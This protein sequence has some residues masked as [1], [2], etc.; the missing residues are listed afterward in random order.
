M[1]L[2]EIKDDSHPPLPV[3][4]SQLLNQENLPAEKTCQASKI[5]PLHHSSKITGLFVHITH[6][7]TSPGNT[8]VGEQVTFTERDHVLHKFGCLYNEKYFAIKCT[9]N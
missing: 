2:A 1:S 6:Q 5:N 8:G 9:I 4:T 7:R 3:S